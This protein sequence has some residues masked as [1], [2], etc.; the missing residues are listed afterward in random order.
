MNTRHLA[1]DL[2]YWL[3]EMVEASALGQKQPLNSIQ[4]LASE[5]LLSGHTGHSPL[6]LLG[7]ASGCFRPEAVIN[8]FPGYEPVQH[9]LE[10]RQL[11]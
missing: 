4:I 2:N 3:S 9:F 1:I 7:E 10:L 6:L 8:L 11:Q 5:R